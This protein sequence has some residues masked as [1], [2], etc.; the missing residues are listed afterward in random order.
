MSNESA[1][2]I[3]LAA[4][5]ARCAAILAVVKDDAA[6]F[7][8]DALLSA[9]ATQVYRSGLHLRAAS[10]LQRLAAMLQAYGSSDALRQA[11]GGRGGRI[12]VPDREPEQ[13]P[14]GFTRDDAAQVKEL[15]VKLAMLLDG[16]P[17]HVGLSALLSMYGTVAA[18]TGDLASAGEYLVKAGLQMGAEDKTPANTVPPSTAV[19]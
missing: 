6:D 14:E 18:C 12:P 3:D 8:I 11:T 16:Y 10:M 7:S 1:A 9:Y 19:H 15:C 5:N 17:N 4:L 13:L 2:P